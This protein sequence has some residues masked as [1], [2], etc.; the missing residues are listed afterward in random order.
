MTTPAHV[1]PATVPAMTLSDG[2]LFE[3]CKALAMRGRNIDAIKLARRVTGVGLAEAK[4]WFEQAV[5]PA[6]VAAITAAITPKKRAP[7]P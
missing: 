4:H 2:L 7:V 6:A 3:A 5:T 1:D